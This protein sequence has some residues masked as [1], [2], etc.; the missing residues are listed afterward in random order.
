M[1]GRRMVHYGIGRAKNAALP[2]HQAEEQKSVKPQNVEVHEGG[3]LP[4]VFVSQVK[5]IFPKQFEVL[6]THYN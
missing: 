5:V 1:D 2:G 3:Q 4:E 6:K